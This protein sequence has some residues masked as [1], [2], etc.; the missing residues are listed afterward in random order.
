MTVY[1]PFDQR[2]HLGDPPWSVD[3][4]DVQ[5][6]EAAHNHDVRLDCYPEFGCVV[7]EIE[8]QM[9][10]EVVDAARSVLW[11]LS[12]DETVSKLSSV[13]RLQ[14]AM[15]HLDGREDSSEE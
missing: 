4:Q 6:W 7:L 1:R 10:Q 5:E 12:N 11:V 14:R 13:V 2:A 15:N 3:R 9:M 8:R